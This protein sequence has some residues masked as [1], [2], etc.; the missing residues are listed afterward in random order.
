MKFTT[1]V[2]IPPPLCTITHSDVGLA[3]GSCFT[4]YIGERLQ[5]LKFPILVN[6][7]GTIYN[8]FSIA[9]SIDILLGN[10]Q[11]Q[12]EDLFLEQGVWQSLYLHT[13][14]SSRNKEDIKQNI[15][16]LQTEFS[17]ILPQLQYIII[18]L[19]TAWVYKHKQLGCIV[20]NCHKLPAHNFERYRLEPKEIVTILANTIELLRSKT[21]TELHIIF[22]V[23]PIRHTK[24]GVFGN[25]V[26]K[27]ALLLA[28]D[29]LLELPNTYYFPAYEIVLDE[30]RDYRFYAQDMIHPSD[31]AVAYIFEKFQST[32][33]NEQ[34]RTM[35][36][37]IESI[38]KAIQHKPF[39]NTNPEYTKF[40][41]NTIEECKLIMQTHTKIDLNYEIELLQNRL[42]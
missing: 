34:T 15:A 27:A 8:P 19:G 39:N 21:N 14:Y 9:Q 41:S 35:C 13:K 11:I 5:Q 6:P 23:S 30:L 16:H 10:K 31:T 18:S 29:E 17:I 42:L 4:T 25:N 38:N 22:T 1:E 20:N 7:L 33:C 3:I 28:I 40:I 37:T 2:A 12:D 24:D 32:M 36:K 26:S